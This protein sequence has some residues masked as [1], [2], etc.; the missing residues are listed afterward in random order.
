VVAAGEGEH[1]VSGR[2]H[3]HGC[4]SWKMSPSFFF[5]ETVKK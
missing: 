3:C 5:E 1:R 4:A 2:E